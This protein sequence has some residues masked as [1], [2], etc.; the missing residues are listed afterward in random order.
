MRV[1][2]TAA[3]VAAAN[4]D[5]LVRW[6]AQCLAPGRAGAA[7]EHAGAVGVRAPALNR[8][9][10]LVLAGPLEGVAA[11]ARAHHEGLKPL[12]VTAQVADLTRL[13][14][15]LAE[16]ATFG[17]MERTGPSAAEPAPPHAEGGHGP[18][19]RSGGTGRTSPTAGALQ[20]G[21][22]ERTQPGR[23]G[24]TSAT[25]DAYPPI[26]DGR[27]PPSLAANTQTDA[28]ALP[29]GQDE[30]SSPGRADTTSAT[31]DAY[32]PI[33]DGWTPPIADALRPDPGARPASAA[34]AEDVRWLAPDEWGG[35]ESLLRK[36]NPHTYVWP[37]EPGPRRW[38]GVHVAGGVVAVGADA[39]SAD[40]VGFVAGVATLPDH[41][42]R[43]FSTAVCAF[44]TDVLLA[45]HGTC[46]LMVDGAN[47]AAIAVYRRLGYVYRS[48]T[49]LRDARHTRSVEQR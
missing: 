47:A 28:G 31:T 17:W 21:Q 34:P 38:A 10:R 9:D 5:P 1:L 30:R 25:T 4:P 33:Q 22:D 41:R 18:H 45:E 23:A 40:G 27:T 26:Q 13:V 24:T 49:A 3:D 46:A 32:P 6:A 29:P 14:P 35:V 11:I 19:R 7:W 44:L 48:V 2:P 39:W 20:P 16:Q 43:G 15:D 12:V 42:G 37:H 8:H 36:A